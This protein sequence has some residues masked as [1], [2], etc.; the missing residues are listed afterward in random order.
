MQEDQHCLT[1]GVYR[2]VVLHP[3]ERR[4]REW[5]ACVEYE[6]YLRVEQTPEVY[7]RIFVT[8]CIRRLIWPFGGLEQ[9][10]EGAIS[11]Q[12]AREANL[13]QRFMEFHPAP[14]NNPRGPYFINNRQPSP[15]V[16]LHVEDSIYDEFPVWYP[17]QKWIDAANPVPSS[18][19]LSER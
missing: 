3:T 15:I 2:P 13:E 6:K 4:R 11:L 16:Y 7:A 12:G 8:L 9:E 17:Y 14:P 19:E 10:A 5:E 1:L 18:I